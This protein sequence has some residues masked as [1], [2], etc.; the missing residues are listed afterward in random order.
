M[1]VTPAGPDQVQ[2]VTSS[3]LDF[4]AGYIGKCMLILSMTLALAAH[5]LR[6]QLSVCCFLHAGAQNKVRTCLMVT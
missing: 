1:A 4:W 3:F 5:T 2:V 6:V